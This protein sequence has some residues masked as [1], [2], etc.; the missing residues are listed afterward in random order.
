MNC[1]TRVKLCSGKNGVW[2]GCVPICA[3]FVPAFAHG[4]PS[5]YERHVH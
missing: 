1:R 4:L 3:A 5:E 2:S